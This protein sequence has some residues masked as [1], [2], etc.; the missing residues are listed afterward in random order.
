MTES[1]Q[2]HGSSAAAQ[3]VS[4]YIKDGDS[5]KKSA[6]VV[7][8]PKLDHMLFQDEEQITIG[9]GQRVPVPFTAQTVDYGDDG[10]SPV[11][12]SNAPIRQPTI[13]LSQ[14]NLDPTLM[15][16]YNPP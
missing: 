6:I 13:G 1:Q 9:G 12:N 3:S 11:A 7:K 16:S 15:V 5:D 4:E 14:M 2:L 8:R 10:M